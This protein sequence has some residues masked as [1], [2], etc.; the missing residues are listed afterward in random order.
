M[1][2]TRFP[3]FT[4]AAASL[5]LFLAVP[6][7]ALASAPAPIG[8]FILA[9]GGCEDPQIHKTNAF[10]YAFNTY[11]SAYKDA[12]WNVQS[13]YDGTAW[14]KDAPEIARRSGGPVRPFTRK[15]FLDGLNA[16]ASDPHLPDQVLIQF[17]THG[18]P[19]EKKGQAS[20]ICLG[21]G[22]MLSLDDPALLG[23]L[24]K[25]KARTHLGIVILSCYS[26][27]S[28]ST[29]AQYGCVVTEAPAN[30]VGY[31]EADY[32]STLTSVIGGPAAR[33]PG[34]R[35]SLADF[36]T[37][38]A[39]SRGNLPIM[40][41]SSD[42][43]KEISTLG[44]SF[45]QIRSR[46]QTSWESGPGNKSLTTVIP[47][48]ALGDLETLIARLR[49]NART[50]S[51]K[52]CQKLKMLMGWSADQDCDPQASLP[53]LEK[54]RQALARFQVVLAQINQNENWFEEHWLNAKFTLPTDFKIDGDIKASFETTLSKFPALEKTYQATQPRIYLGLGVAPDPQKPGQQTLLWTRVGN[55]N[56]PVSQLPIFAPGT[57][58]L[59]F[60]RTLLRNA[61]HYDPPVSAERFE[62]DAQALNQAL[63]KSEAV[64]LG[65]FKNQ[66]Y[67]EAQARL[68]GL[69]VSLH[70][71]EAHTNPAGTDAICDKIRDILAKIRPVQIM[72]ERAKHH[73]NACES[74]TLS[75]GGAPKNNAIAVPSDE[76]P[77]GAS[78]R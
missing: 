54:Y 69:D 48:S 26:G 31:S 21:D 3:S 40:S 43:E 27:G 9:G 22:S 63:V 45:Q 75:R 14:Q 41:S 12:G 66:E 53:E 70:Q 4:S 77:H 32:E 46:Y 8:D 7:S 74:F 72:A 68:A 58:M 51:G 56:L 55:R 29:L 17:K 34:G 59:E 47:D 42:A 57:D 28:V 25:L 11:P 52:D 10:L 76:L 62:S 60:I 39:G 16:L 78:A 61:G 73:R 50:I 65:T 33:L 20:R 23:A 24:A 71:V 67:A 5:G 35:L 44:G 30:Q 49:Q 1:N 18:E 37:Q 38:L 6:G 19:G 2:K 64:A 15:E 13:Y 36:F